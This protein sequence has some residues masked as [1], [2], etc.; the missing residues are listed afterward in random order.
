MDDDV[1]RQPTKTESCER[2]T[3]GRTKTSASRYNHNLFRVYCAGAGDGAGD[4]PEE[5]DKLYTVQI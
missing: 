4:G 3:G 1:D 2:N 5:E